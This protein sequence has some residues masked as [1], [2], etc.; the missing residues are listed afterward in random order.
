[1]AADRREA[2]RIIGA[3]GTTCAFPYSADQLY[4]QHAHP[5]GRPEVAGPLPPAPRFFTASEF[6]VIARLADLIIPT[7]DTPG[8]LAAGVPAYIDYVVSNNAQAQRLCREG[9]HW[10]D[11][12]C[13]QRH[14]KPFV[15]LSHE[16]QVA[17]LAPLCEA[18]DQIRE[19]PP[20][21]GL[22]RSNSKLKPGVALFRTVKS[23]TADG[24]FTSKEG[25]VETLGYRGNT[26][27]AEFPAC[28]HE[29]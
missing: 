5:D 12:Q 14:G 26:V 27:L 1:M 29:H 25:L 11:R 10:L 13:R 17:L 8:A 19:A 18:A 15:E 2:L 3:V 20:G 21:S 24:F 4:G 9:L 6:A 23:L 7:T 28:T 22:R 16:Q